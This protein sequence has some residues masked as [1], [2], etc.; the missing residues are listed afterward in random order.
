MVGFFK[1]ECESVKNY[2]NINIQLKYEQSF[3]FLFWLCKPNFFKY[4]L[5]VILA[6]KK[7]SVKDKNNEFG[8]GFW[9]GW[10]WFT[11]HWAKWKLD[12]WS[13]IL[14]KKQLTPSTKPPSPNPLQENWQF[15][16]SMH[17][18]GNNRVCFHTGCLLGNGQSEN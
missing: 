6:R 9:N 5:Y 1:H 12:H 8:F 10:T 13:E 14:F 17:V 11:C 2:R 7:A 18:I 4:L 3:D 16:S 15:F